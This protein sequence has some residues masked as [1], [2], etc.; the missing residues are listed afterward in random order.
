[1]PQII[2]RANEDALSVLFNTAFFNQVKQNL[3]YDPA[4]PCEDLPFDI[5]SLLA[6]AVSI[7]ETQQWRF[8]RRKPVTMLLPYEAFTENDCMVFLPYGPASSLSSFTYTNTSNQS[9]TV[10]SSDYTLYPGE[11]IKLWANNWTSVLT[12]IDT[13]LPYPVSITYTTGYSSFSAIPPSTLRA[14]KILAYHIHEYRDAIAEGNA[15]ILPQGYE[16]HR[17]LALLNCHRAIKYTAE[18]YDKVGR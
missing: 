3:G 12:D 15:N 11:P 18:D 16:Y 7:V 1:M 8:I 10:S 9:V 14:I 2:D 17:D 5:D 4:T 13:D 6:E